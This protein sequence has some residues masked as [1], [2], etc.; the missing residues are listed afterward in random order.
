MTILAFNLS[1]EVLQ[2]PEGTSVW[3]TSP[4]HLV[5][6]QGLLLLPGL[7][8][9]FFSM[10]RQSFEV[11]FFFY[12]LV[13]IILPLSGRGRKAI[14]IFNLWSNFVS[15]LSEIFHPKCRTPKIE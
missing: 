3:L 7:T 15:F 11:L 14:F 1:S 10:W 4:T 6:L 5:K 9:M 12:S 13:W 8:F 2:I